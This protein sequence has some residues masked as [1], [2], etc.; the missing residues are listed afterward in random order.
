M[1]HRVIVYCGDYEAAR[2]QYAIQ[3][4]IAATALSKAD[5][6]QWRVV[7]PRLSSDGPTTWRYRNGKEEA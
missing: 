7:D 1:N 2:F 5:G 4:H 6:N 3:A